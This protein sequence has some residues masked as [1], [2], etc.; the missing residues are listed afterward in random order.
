MHATDVT[1]QKPE[2]CTRCLFMAITGYWGCGEFENLDGN[3]N[4]MCA[5]NMCVLSAGLTC[6]CR[7]QVLRYG[8]SDVHDSVMKHPAMDTK[9]AL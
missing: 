5:G 9:C 8:W 3:G 4:A 1:S 7:D 6:K 2:L